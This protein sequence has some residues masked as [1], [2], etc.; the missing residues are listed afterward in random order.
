MKPCDFI[1]RYETMSKAQVHMTG[2]A[3]VDAEK[4]LEENEE[5]YLKLINKDKLKL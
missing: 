5:K 3:Y 2:E 4:W 1:T